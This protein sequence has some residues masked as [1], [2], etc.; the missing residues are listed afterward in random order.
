MS[1]PKT[2][3]AVLL[4]GYGGFDQLEYREDV[5]VPKPGTGE[6]LIQVGAAGINNTDINTRT[7]WYSKSVSEGTTSEAGKAGFA[8]TNPADAGWNGT[9][10]K[11]PLIQGIDACGRIVAVG[12]HVGQE[13]IGQ[14]VLVE[15]ALRE[16]AGWRPFEAL[17]LGSEVDG[18]FAEFVK[19]PAVHAHAIRS[20]LSD[21]ELASFPCAYSTAENMIERAGVAKDE[22]VLITGASG[23]VGSAAVQLANRRG[24]TVTAVTSASKAEQVRALGAA[25]IVERGAA[26]KDQL[27]AES[28]DVI[29]DVAGGPEWPA[30]LDALKR[31]G[32]YAVSGAIAGPMVSLDLR[33]LYLK[34][35]RLLGCTVL[36]RPVFANLIRYIERDEISPVVAATYPLKEI[37][38]AQQDFLAKGF[39]GKLVLIP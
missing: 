37:V 2:M 32:R 11:F 15:P 28:F 33:T 6:V 22:A 12:D 18:G 24:A 26:L 30:L 5:P 38:R 34:D 7:G 27:Q 36:D 29:I 23:G 20:S 25:Y 14:R 1:L 35:L 3:K 19:V 13:R 31:G 9:G 10:H 8:A 39:V 17:Y 16:P 4:K 21:A